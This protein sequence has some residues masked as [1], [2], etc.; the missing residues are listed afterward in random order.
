METPKNDP[1]LCL[2]D[3][4]EASITET[5]KWSNYYSND[6]YNWENPPSKPDQRLIDHLVK[7]PET[8]KLH[9]YRINS[10]ENIL[11]SKRILKML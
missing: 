3:K 8:R 5:N 11:P 4:N 1:L 2:A 10:K 6:S 7:E 9:V